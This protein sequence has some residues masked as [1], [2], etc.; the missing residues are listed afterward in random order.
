MKARPTKQLYFARRYCDESISI[1]TSHMQYSYLPSPPILMIIMSLDIF[2]VLGNFSTHFVI[3]PIM[4]EPFCEQRP[5]TG[6]R[7]LHKH[8]IMKVH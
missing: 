1:P 4:L 2:Y 6:N 7:R 3:S 8:F 5:E